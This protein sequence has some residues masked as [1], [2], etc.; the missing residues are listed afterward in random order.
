MSLFPEPRHDAFC[1][2]LMFNIEGYYTN[3]PHFSFYYIGKLVRD[4]KENSD[5]YS[6]LSEVCNIDR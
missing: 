4:E 6:E 2:G 1:L 3:W 5:W